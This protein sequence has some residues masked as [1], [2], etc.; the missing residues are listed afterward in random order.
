ML[1]L[2]AALSLTLDPAQLPKQP[3][4]W[5]DGA[6]TPAA[7]AENPP[8]RSA[9]WTGLGTYGLAATFAG[10]GGV[11]AEYMTRSTLEGRNV[12]AGLIGMAA[13]LAV[14]LV[15]GYLL[16]DSARNESND[17]GR[18]AVVLLDTAG[19]AAVFFAL[20]QIFKKD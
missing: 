12:K 16:G 6:N 7:S 3:A 14:G 1:S 5:A 8:R 18:G 10:G 20:T 4:P 11:V 15:P 19:T 2:L 9:L 13:G 17:K